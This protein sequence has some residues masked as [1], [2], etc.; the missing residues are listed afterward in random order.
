DRCVSQQLNQILHHADFQKLEASWRGLAHLANCQ[1]RWSGAPTIIRVLNVTWSEL[2]RDFENANE[3]D[4]SEIYRKV[5]QEG[6][7]QAG[8][9]PF[10]SIILDY[11]I[12]PKPTREHPFDDIEI[13]TRLAEVGQASFC[14]M[15]ANAHPTMF[16]EDAFSDLRPPQG[17]RDSQRREQDPY[18]QLHNSLGF[19]RW[20]KFRGAESA[21]FM[22]LAM[23]RMLMRRP[24]RPGYSRYFGFGFEEEVRSSKE[25]L[26]GGAA[27]GAGE[28]L[29]RAFSEGSWFADIRGAQRGSDHGGRVLGPTYDAFS[30]EP[31]DAVTKPVTDMVIS[32]DFERSLSKLGFMPL[33]ACKDMPIAA[34]YSAATIQQPALYNDEQ[35]SFNARISTMLNYM[36]CASR[37]AH[38]V[39]LITRDRIGSCNSPEELERLLQNWLADYIC[40]SDAELSIRAEKPLRDAQI[41][42]WKLPGAAGEFKSILHIAPHF[43]FE[44]VNALVVLQDQKLVSRN[45]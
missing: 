4:Q 6:I 13:L 22:S 42:I 34:F 12:H 5:H 14:P 30:T 25:Y 28:V 17:A 40:D 20:K 19:F 35:A 31:R 11:A 15:I 43:G 29:L 33:C 21:R 16:E 24:Y 1:D 10:S 41:K 36:L 44:D 23:P 3:F 26:W 27:F 9:N 32:D 38:Y 8:A 39:K 2:R 37:F 18:E 45:T 7:G